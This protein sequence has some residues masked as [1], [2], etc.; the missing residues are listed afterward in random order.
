[1]TA[2]SVSFEMLQH[3]RVI[4]CVHCLMGHHPP[5]CGCILCSLFYEVQIIGF[6]LLK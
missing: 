2:K 1:M 4:Y 6:S 3:L 5:E